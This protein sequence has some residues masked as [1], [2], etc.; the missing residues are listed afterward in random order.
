MSRT[1]PGRKS[2]GNPKA[3]RQKSFRAVLLGWYDRHARILPWRYTSGIKANPYYVWLSE[4]MLQQTTVQAVIPY[5]GKFVDKW[6]TVEKLAAANDEDVMTAWAGLGYYARARNLLKCARVV[7]GEYKGRFPQT[8][9]SLKNLPGIGDYTAAAIAS[10]AFNIPATVIDGN[11]DRVVSRYFA[12]E[13]PLPDSKPEIREKAK[14]MFEGEDIDRPGDFAQAMM[15]L[16]ATICTPKSPK[17]MICPVSENCQA[18]IF[19]VT[20]ELPR[21]KEKIDLPKREGYIYW[22]TNNKGQV[23]FEKRPDKGLLGG[24]TG[25]PTSDWVAPAKIS[26][27]SDIKIG[28]TVQM[29]NNYKIRHTFTH[30]HLEL[31]GVFLKVPRRFKPAGHQFW[32]STKEISGLGLPTVFKKFVRLCLIE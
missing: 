20:G 16:G 13:N 12:I 8:L 31:H 2:P 26:H 25:L 1:M 29:D 18:R 23:L 28:D 11:V 15:D 6:P 30:F 17:C 10:I 7:T 24:M 22:I 4:V 21:R 9:E 3:F 5:F 19:G 27:I 32:I 14:L